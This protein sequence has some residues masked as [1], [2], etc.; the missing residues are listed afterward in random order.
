VFYGSSLIFLLLIP[1]I[2]L[3]QPRKQGPTVT[4]DAAAGAH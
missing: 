1:L 4:A 2:W 3:S